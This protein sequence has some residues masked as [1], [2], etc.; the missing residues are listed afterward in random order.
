MSE[1]RQKVDG[2]FKGERQNKTEHRTGIDGDRTLVMTEQ[3]SGGGD[4][5]GGN[6]GDRD[7][8]RRRNIR[9]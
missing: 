8:S 3:G 6:D 7:I 4:G 9:A 1:T 5:G 2:L